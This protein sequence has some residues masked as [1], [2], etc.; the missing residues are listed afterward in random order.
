MP[1]HGS[2]GDTVVLGRTE[3]TEQCPHRGEG[4]EDNSTDQADD[5]G[6][7]HDEEQELTSGAGQREP[8]VVDDEPELVEDRRPEHAGEHVPR[9]GGDGG[10]RD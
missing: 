9:G 1:E 7:G 4:E 8:G 2:S 3:L 5:V 10:W 6:A